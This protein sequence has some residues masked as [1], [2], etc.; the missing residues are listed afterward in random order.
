MPDAAFL[1]AELGF[2][3]QIRSLSPEGAWVE[4]GRPTA[5]QPVDALVTL[6]IPLVLTVRHLLC[7][8]VSSWDRPLLVKQRQLVSRCLL[9]ALGFV[10]PSQAD[11]NS[12]GARASF[13][14]QEK[15]WDK[16]RET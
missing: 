9:T 12:A 7:A 4:E 6:S 8:G 3:G 11:Q 10:S 15:T 16:D 2:G 5:Q 1:G 14:R 13:G